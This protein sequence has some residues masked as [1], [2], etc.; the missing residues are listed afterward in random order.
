MKE[1]KEIVCIG[2]ATSYLLENMTEKYDEEYVKKQIEMFGYDP[3]NLI[4]DR[5]IITDRNLVV[6]ETPQEHS[7][8]RPHLMIKGCTRENEESVNNGKGTGILFAR[9]SIFYSEPSDYTGNYPGDV[10]Y[11]FDIPKNPNVVKALIKNDDFLEAIVARDEAKIRQALD[12]F[13]SNIEKPILVTEYL[14]E[15]LKY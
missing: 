14:T 7:P 12:S 1:R 4:K 8:N 11:S 10:G 2:I 5:N 9:Y 15:A 3:N 13:N 6:I